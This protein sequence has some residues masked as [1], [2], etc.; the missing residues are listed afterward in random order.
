MVCSSS[1]KLIKEPIKVKIPINDANF[2]K[3]A[4]SWKYAIKINLPN[5]SMDVKYKINK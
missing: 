3:L 1:P 5:P 4:G 2:P